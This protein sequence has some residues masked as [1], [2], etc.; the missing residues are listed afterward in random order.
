[1]PLTPEIQNEEAESSIEDDGFILLTKLF[2][3]VPLHPQQIR[4]MVKRG[5][6]PRPVSLSG[7]TAFRRKEIR[8]WLREQR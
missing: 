3:L 6:F 4:K 8:R 7:R 5:L 1:M 2:E